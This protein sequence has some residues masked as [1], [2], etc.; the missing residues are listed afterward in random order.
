M[1]GGPVNDIDYF[2]EGVFPRKAVAVLP[3]FVL[4]RGWRPLDVSKAIADTMWEQPT[5]RVYGRV[6]L[7]PRLTAWFGDGAYTY[8]GKR[9]EPAP[10]PQWVDDA[11]REIEAMTGAKFNSVLLN[12]YRDGSDSVAWHADDEPELGEEPMIASWSLGMPRMFSVKARYT[13]VRWSA[14]LGCGDLLIMKGRSQADYL[15]SV[16]KTTKPIGP[17]VN[18]TFRW[19]K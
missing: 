1:D 19:V 10:M 2:V 14:Q 12:Y 16:P 4:L 18:L 17:R 11:R 3:G 5:L 15:H 6:C 7:A 9:Q 13:D 8:S